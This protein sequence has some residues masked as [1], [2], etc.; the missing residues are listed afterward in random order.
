VAARYVAFRRSGWTGRPAAPCGWLVGALA[1][2]VV[3]L[4]RVASLSGQPSVAAH[5]CYV[6]ELLCTCDIGA[7]RV[8][9]PPVAYSRPMF[10]GHESPFEKRE[11]S[12]NAPLLCS[13]IHVARGDRARHGRTAGGSGTSCV[14][15]RPARSSTRGVRHVPAVGR[16]V[17]LARHQAR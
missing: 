17:G 14:G 4:R 9:K 11:R 10:T 8:A 3:S 13:H 2:G 1:P 6:C 15:G 12:Q 7:L 16:T 5:M